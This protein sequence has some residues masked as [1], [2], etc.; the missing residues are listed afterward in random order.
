M[1]SN[2]SA[3]L[4]FFC[5]SASPPRRERVF[6]EEVVE[7]DDDDEEEEGEDVSLRER[8]ARYSHDLSLAPFRLLLGR[9]PLPLLLVLF[10]DFLRGRKD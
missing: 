5:T 6:E 9:P 10:N 8:V 4:Q 2:I 3:H 7:D 1:A